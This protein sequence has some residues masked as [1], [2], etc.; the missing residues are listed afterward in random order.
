MNLNSL[1]SSINKEIF[2]NST[3]FRSCIIVLVGVLL[4]AF[5]API[6]MYAQKKTTTKTTTTKATTPAS[7]PRLIINHFVSDPDEIEPILVVTDVDGVGPIIRINVYDADGKL[8]YDKS[9]VLSPFGKIN[10]NAGEYVK[11]AKMN[12]TIRIESNG[13]KIA[14]QYWQFYKGEDKGYKDV[15]MP[16]GDGTGFTKLIV[17]HF[18]SHPGVV[19]SYLVVAN[20][21]KDKPTVINV[22][23]YDDQGK[24][25]GT[26]RKIVQPNGKIIFEPAKGV[27]K[28]MTGVAYIE[29]EGGN[30]I[31]GEYWQNEEG[32]KYQIVLPLEG[33]TKTR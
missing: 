21:E 29:T 8:Q 13:G 31:T 16:A 1:I 4:F 28:Q 10:V 23:Y 3:F 7:K 5:C 24:I 26:E 25:A 32:K 6:D 22:K 18:V 27:N 2:M 9:E 20:A 33:I 14:G 30:K 19:E 17:Q 11:H 15:A 12:G